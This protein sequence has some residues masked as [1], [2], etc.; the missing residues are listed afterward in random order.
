[1]KGFEK[2]RMILREL[3]ERYMEIA[4]LPVQEEKKRL[5]RA[6]NGL[7]PERPMV[8]IEQVCW[9][10]M[11]IDDKLTLRCENGECRGYEWFFRQTLYRWEYFP[12]DM[13]IEP[14]VKISKAIRDSDFGVSVKESTL[15]TSETNATVSHRYE[16]QFKTMEDVEKIK[17]PVI[18][19][20]EAETRRR[21][22]TASWLFDGIMP[23]RAEG[24]NNFYLAPW[25]FLTTWMGVENALYAL[26]DQG[27]MIHA[28]IKRMVDGYMVMLD[29]LEDQGLLGGPQGEV[30]CTGAFTND[31]PA[32][33]YDPAKPRTKDLWMYTMAQMLATVSPAMHE[34]YDINYIKPLCERF[35]LVYY[36]CC[37]PLHAKVGIVRKLPH[38]R[39]ISMSPWVDKKQ[40]AEAIH[41]DYVYSCKPNP[42]FVGGPGFNAGLVRGDLEETKKICAQTGC[43]VEFILKD[44]STVRGEPARLQ[45]WAEIAMETALS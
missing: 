40:G 32:P 3:A 7:K 21:M 43:P 44:I 4:V 42:A 29:Q 14:V 27:E 16:N 10:E 19:H 25:D 11:N 28:I 12:V 20:D 41:G 18:T 39:K 45:K 24:R 5:W 13:V 8:A 9:N 17:V 15:A 1:M 26:I 36:G 6:L 37:E 31:L 23:V 22:D 30:H 38:V 33:G 35:G 2:D 34:E